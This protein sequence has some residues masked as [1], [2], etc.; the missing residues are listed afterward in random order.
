M[1]KD[2]IYPYALTQLQRVKDRI[3]DTNSQANFT[4]TTNT[5]NS[6]TAVTQTLGMVVG[7]A[8]YGS[9][10]PYG[11]TISAIGNTTI[12]L[13]QAATSSASGVA[14]TTLLQ[15]VAFDNVLIRMINACTDWIERECGGRRFAQ[16]L[17]N[18][19]V[20]SATGAKQKYL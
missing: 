20:Y 6:L 10:I 13:S 1:N 7:Q 18:N 14:I 5:S 2:T 4:A 12:T 8:I 16:T 11:T 15:P 9:G 19:E 17:Y 3:F